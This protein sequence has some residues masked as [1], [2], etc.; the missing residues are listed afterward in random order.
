MMSSVN[1]NLSRSRNLNNSLVAQLSAESGLE[2]LILCIEEVRM[3]SSTDADTYMANLAGQLGEQLDGTVNLN[4]QTVSFSDGM[5]SIPAI[6]VG[7]ATFSCSVAV[8]A[9]DGDGTPQCR[10]SASAVSGSAPRT[11]S[12]DLKLVPR[13]AEVFD[14][15]VA[16]RGSIYV[17]GSATIDG[18]NSPDEGSIL[19]LDSDALA[20]SIGG[21]A[22][23]GGD[24]YLTAEGEDSIALTGGGLSVGGTSDTAEIIDNHVHRLTEEPDFP[25]LD[26][27]PFS[28]LTTS[29][30][31]SNTDL[32][33]PGLV[34]N[35]IHITAGTD[36][37]FM[38][39]TVI[40]GIIY[41]EAP[42]NI[43]FKS[44]VTLNAIIVT[45]D[46]SAMPIADN[47]LNFK[48]QVTAPGV[49][50][51]PDTPEF[52]AVKQHNGTIILA[53]GF[54]VQFCGAVNSINGTI[55]AD[56]FSFLGN[57]NVSGEIAG[58]ILGLSN[59]DLVMQGN[60]TILVNRDEADP[61][62]AGFVHYK[63]MSLVS[64]SYS[65]SH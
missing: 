2:F 8:I 54:G 57:A 27:T 47:Q 25:E 45:E 51:L 18:M 55:A 14:Y 20:I 28:A 35:N 44:K 38:Q 56:Q 16:S 53:P 37:E 49:G 19:S 17:S 26:L 59:A 10:L 42:N 31:D 39:D 29:V 4:G 7:M 13:T 43:V 21:H 64:G 1:M 60:A 15:A 34:F 65:E 23:V 24:L 32:T 50:A 46:A 5:I 22:T 12:V 9:P 52:A 62:P 48:G 63:G 36:P 58:S 41:V 3:P 40:N 61:T 11:A 30:I 33:G 6:T